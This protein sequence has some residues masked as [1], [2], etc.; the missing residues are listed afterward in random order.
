MLCDSLWLPVGVHGQEG[1]H[2]GLE[3]G[4]L[5]AEL[6]AGF[7][8]GRPEGDQH[9]PRILVKPALQLPARYVLESR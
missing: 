1:R 6:A 4:E 5:A 7:A 9:Q 2:L 3:P 8:A